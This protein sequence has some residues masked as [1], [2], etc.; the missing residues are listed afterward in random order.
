VT[1][2]VS[3]PRATAHAYDRLH[4]R[5]KTTDARGKDTTFGYNGREDLTSVADPRALLTTYPRN[6]LGD[7]LGLTSPDT[8]TATHAVDAAGNLKTRLDSRG[9]LA[10]YDYDA[11]NRLRG[12]TYTQSGQPTQAFI[13]NYDQ[14]GAGFSHGVGRLTS[15]QFPSGS[16]TYAYDALGRLTS[17]TQIVQSV[18]TV[19]LTTGYGYDAAGRITSITYP[20]GRV[21]HITHVGGVPVGLSVAPNAGSAAVALIS[22]LVF[23]PQP[24]GN[25]PARSW[26]W[27]L[28]SGTLANER[29]FDTWGRLV[30]Y[31]LGG[32][33]RD[34]TYDAA[35][36]ISSYTHYNAVSGAAVPQLDQGFGYDELG[37]LISISTGPGSWVLGYDDNGNRTIVGYTP[38][39]GGTNYR[40]YTTAANSNRLLSLNYPTKTFTHDAAGNTVQASDPWSAATATYDL[41]GRMSQLNS[42]PDL[43]NYLFNQIAE[44]PAITL[45]RHLFGLF[46]AAE[47]RQ[48]SMPPLTVN[49]GMGGQVGAWVLGVAF[50]GGAAFSLPFDTVCGYGQFSTIDGPQFVLAGGPVVGVS[51]GAPSPG[52]TKARGFTFFGGSGY[53]GNVQV[54]QTTEGDI[55]ASRATVRGNFGKG[56]GAGYVESWQLMLCN[57][58]PGN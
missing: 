8:G 57:K 11:L 19:A 49:F 30:R 31:P 21:L 24:G 58:P 52:L 55:Q 13:W 25:G 51:S 47:D 35:D 34:I 3:A 41:A 18:S 32:A 40:N 45:R 4:R 7:T 1:A 39:G 15:T 14:T 53:L 10:S 17:T 20:S 37:R 6:G 29:V 42:N 2:T 28:N 36:R 56:A 5:S 23:E 22:N 54:L 48:P 46:G 33:V 43:A 16:A 27:H 26:L 9:V 38:A 44:H 50:E 12:I